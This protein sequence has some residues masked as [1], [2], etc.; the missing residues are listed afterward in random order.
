[1]TKQEFFAMRDQQR[2]SGELPQVVQVNAPANNLTPGEEK[3]ILS[4][5]G[6][7]DSG[8]A[9]TT[10]LGLTRLLCVEVY[11]GETVQVQRKKVDELDNVTIWRVK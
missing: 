7:Q 9:R 3:K 1:M 8:M 5:L 11:T 4:Y 6:D 2:V 10:D